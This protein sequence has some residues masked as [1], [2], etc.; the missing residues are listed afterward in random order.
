LLVLDKFA[1]LYALVALA[2][3]ADLAGADAWAASTLGARDAL[4]ERT[5]H[6]VALSLVHDLGMEAER[7]VRARLD[8]EQWAK[9]DAAGRMIRTTGC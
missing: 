2:I 3:A 1:Y 7:N 4:L 5:G 9:A 8:P 6:T